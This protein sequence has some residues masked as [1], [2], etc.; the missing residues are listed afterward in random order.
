M[1]EPLIYMN[2]SGVMTMLITNNNHI[3]IG[4]G[5][6]SKLIPPISEPIN[7]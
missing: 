7:A 5:Q 2:V 4:P 1:A 3:Y 6:A